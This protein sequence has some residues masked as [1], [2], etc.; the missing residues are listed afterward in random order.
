MKILF[1]SYYFPPDLSAGSFRSDALVDALLGGRS[2]V[3]I[4]VVTTEPN[5]YSGH[6]PTV[7]QP[8]RDRLTVTRVP[9]AAHR[10]GMFDQALGYAP[11]VTTVRRVA[12]REDFDL[13]YATS[14]RL[15]TAVLGATVASRRAPLYLDIRDIF[16]DTM[17]DVLGA[18]HAP[19]MPALKKLEQFAIRTAK[20]VNVVSAAFEPHF[21]K[22]DPSPKYRVFTNGIDPQFIRQ[23]PAPPKRLAPRIVYAGNIGE[24]QGLH[25]I[26]PE[27]ARRLGERAVLR[28]IGDGGRKKELERSVAEFDNVELV[29]PMSREA[30]QAEYDEANMLLMHL[31]DYRAFRKVLPSKLFEY[32]ALERPILAGVAGHSRE[33]LRENMIGCEIFDPCDADGFV[34]AFDKLVQGPRRYERSSFVSR[35]GRQAIMDE[36]AQDI[37][38]A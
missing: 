31:N 21:K 8:T 12:K 36:M 34:K 32:G 16:T 27:V 20:K 23:I 25:K 2:D 24:G 7:E 30:L 4:H 28:I 29:E 26:V 35:F 9:V 3:Q 38:A 1:L 14:S 18:K 5:R 13:V 37:L 17:I 10:S 6:Q 33:F 15:M 22:V 19:I 11:F